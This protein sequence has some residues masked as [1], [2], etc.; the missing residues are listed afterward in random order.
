[1]EYTTSMKLDVNPT[2][3]PPVV[4]VK[5]GDGSARLLQIQLQKDGVNWTPESGLAYLFRCQKPDGH[6]VLED[7]L[8]QDAELERYL[9]V[10]Q[11]SGVIQIELIEQTATAVG[12]CRCDLCL[13]KDEKV[14]STIPFVIEVIASPN[15]A[16]LAV[17]T[18][19]FRTMTNAI[20]ELADLLDEVMPV[21][22]TLTLSTSWNGSASPY[23]QAVT[24]SGYNVT[25]HTKVDLYGSADVIATM[26]TQRTDEI[27]VVNNDGVLT[28]YAVGE[29]PTS[30]MTVQASLSETR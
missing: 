3:V 24:V 12:V 22:S 26:K 28:A 7:S 1:M 17:S 20:A 19:D 27:M 9:V 6:A 8:T 30:A 23:S 4:R 14:L 13:I 5:Q 25:A 2:G 10:N 16:T 15:V 21:I 11:G 18:D 29:K